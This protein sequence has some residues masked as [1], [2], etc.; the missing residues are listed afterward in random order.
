MKDK[1]LIETYKKVDI[2]YQKFDGRLWFEFEDN[3][4]EVKYLFEAKAFNL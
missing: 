3:E 1:V 2:Y 4:N